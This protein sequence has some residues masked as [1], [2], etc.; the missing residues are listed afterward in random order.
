MSLPFAFLK[1]PLF[2]VAVALVFTVVGGSA[3]DVAPVARDLMEKYKPALVVVTIEGTLEA[4]TD[5]E[6][7][8]PRPQSRRTLGVTVNDSGL[9]IVSNSAIDASVGLAGQQARTGEDGQVVTIQTAKSLF[10]VVNISYGDKTSLPGTVVHQD[11]DA[12][13]AFILPDA[14]AA[15]RVQKTFAD[16]TLDL[17]DWGSSAQA[18][19]QV[20]GLS[21]S[22]LAYGYMSTVIVGRITG[23]FEGNRRYYV[24]TAGTAQ[25]IPVFTMDGKAVGVTLERILD[26]RRTGILGTLSAG[27]IKTLADLAMGTAELN[28]PAPA[29]VEETAPA[30]TPAPETPEAPAAPA[31]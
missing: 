5:G 16:A 12:D 29:P 17:S 25:G 31:Q 15:K 2:A 23:V 11:L 18:A 1:R 30:A 22:S 6:P 8:D 28:P 27:S 7:L 10:S 19:D 4:S 20:V 14:G 26:G 3:Q 21:R 9:V 13:A 24:T